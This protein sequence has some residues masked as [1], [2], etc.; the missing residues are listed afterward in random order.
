[1]AHCLIVGGTGMLRTVG[2]VF[3]E[4]GHRVSVVARNKERLVGLVRDTQR[5]PGVINPIVADYT[6]TDEFEKKIREAKA[7]LGPISVAVLWIH[8][9]AGDAAGAVARLLNDQTEPCQ[10]Y[11]VLGSQTADPSKQTGD[12]APFERLVHI[13]YRSVILGFK[14]E[15]AGSRW[16]TNDEIASG[17]LDAIANDRTNSVVGTIEPWDQRP[18]S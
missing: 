8:S 1:M 6:R 5:S 14:R 2:V 4:A 9:D 16:L 11:H 17:V 7:I 10:L 15:P 18:G 12:H 13:S 3:A